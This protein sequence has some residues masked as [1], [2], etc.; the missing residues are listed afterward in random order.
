[1]LDP[2]EHGHALDLGNVLEVQRGNGHR[3]DTSPGRVLA[4]WSWAPSAAATHL[5][6]ER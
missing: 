3:E 5:V 6:M 2:D 4:I 1:V